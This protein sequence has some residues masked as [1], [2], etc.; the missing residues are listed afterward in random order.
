MNPLQQQELERYLNIMH[1]LADLSQEVITPFFRKKITVDEKFDKGIYDPVTAADRNAEQVIREFIEQ[2]LPDHSIIGEEFGEVQRSSDYCWII[3][4]IDG[5][6][7]FVMGSPLWGTLIGLTYKSTPLLGMMNQPFTKERFWTSP[8]GAIGRWDGTEHS[9]TTSDVTELSK[10]VIT[11]TCPDLFG[12]S[13]D[14]QTFDKLRLQC[15]MTRYGGDCYSYC[16]LAMGSVDIIV[17]S[18]L[19]SYDIAPLVPIVQAA[20]GVITNWQGECA[21]EGGK[22][23]AGATP[24][25]HELALKELKSA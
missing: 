19:Q 4:P 3:D 18:G 21:G 20:G 12:H 7:A 17:E 5:T 2:H 22:I 13:E 1:E 14:L 23:I 16:L 6:R 24:A 25:L 11:S 15:R 9:L 10:A 8:E